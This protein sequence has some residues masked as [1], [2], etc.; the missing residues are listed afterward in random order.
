MSLHFDVYEAICAQALRL[1]VRLSAQDLK[2]R[3]PNFFEDELA[4]AGL[5]KS[6]GAYGLKA[7]WC[8]L[9]P[10]DIKPSHGAVCLGCE[11]GSAYLV[12]ASGADRLNVLW[13]QTSMRIR[14]ANELESD[15][16][17]WSVLMAVDTVVDLDGTTSGDATT[18]D[19]WFWSAMGSLRPYYLDCVLAAI[20]INCLALAASMFSMNV[21]DRIIPTGA[22]Q[23][24]WVL[25]VGVLVAAVFEFL[26][27]VLRGY[28][29]DV[30]GKKADLVL[31]SR[32]FAH[33]LNLRPE[34]RPASSG[35][36]A[37]QLKDF[38]SV[39][40]FVSSATLVVLSDLPFALLFLAVIAWM[41]GVLVWVPLLGCVLIVVVGVLL[42]L[43]VKTAIER[44][45]Y[46][47]TQK[48]GFMVEVLERLETVKAL[49]IDGRLQ[50]QWETLSA[51]SSRSAMTSRLVS[52][53][54][55][56][57]T[58]FIQQLANVL[59]IVWGVYLIWA[60]QLSMGALIGCTILAGRALGPM[61]QLSGLMA[62]YQNAAVAYKALDKLMRQAGVY[63]PRKTYLSLGSVRGEL[64]LKDVRFTYPA[65]EHP[66][67]TIPH[68]TIAP[69]ERVVVMGPVG[70]GKSTLL[71][72]L[73]NLY[74]SCAGQVL[75]D[76][77]DIAQIAQGDLRSHV[78][79]VGQEVVL[80]RATLRENLLM[81]APD[82]S[83][84]R[85][86]QVLELTGMLPWV[87]VHPLG[88]DMPLGENGGR[89]SGG[90]RQMVA[91]ARA[92]LSDAA[93]LL[94]DEPTSALDAVGERRLIEA[95]DKALAGRTVVLATH[96]PGPM[97]L[98]HR[99]LVLDGGELVADG[100]KDK[101]L[102]ALQEGRVKRASVVDTG[103]GHVG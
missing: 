8:D 34:S 77:V 44:Y 95:L 92:L 5:I 68:L 82:V 15:W 46:E 80:F 96:R 94:L 65:S 102:A 90:Q 6:L 75:F 40:D 4:R 16:A 50:G 99:M 22:L 57:F 97:H 17:G 39:R 63:H 10:V 61:G 13:P 78:A 35:Q 41:G 60:G 30:A 71:R 14:S 73:G 51:L 23:S 69:G 58:Q 2:M 103:A 53:I 11:N 56:N 12:V 36:M 28:L 45:Q 72:V 93:V 37:A 7:Q 74:P 19:H 88:L 62:R 33:L 70:S 76:G 87:M 100:P 85:L 83:D 49:G 64:A 86:K 81:G 29:V 52:A 26:L 43:P 47:T 67:L 18:A 79:W 84:E 25:A 89:L 66:V 32:L 48:H 38:D 55:L 42:Q 24:L 54:S 98:A 20:L 59:L 101:V 91:L 27:R 9:S 1:G 31:S 21:Y 3:A